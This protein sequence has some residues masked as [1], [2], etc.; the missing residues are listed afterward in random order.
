M[1]W[2]VT[3]YPS[4]STTLWAVLE[5]CVH[6]I[7]SSNALAWRRKQLGYKKGGG[8]CLARRKCVPCC[9]RCRRWCGWWHSC[10]LWLAKSQGQDRWKLLLW[11]SLWDRPQSHFWFKKLDIFK[12]ILRICIYVQHSCLDGG[13]VGSDAIA[14]RIDHVRKANICRRGSFEVSVYHI[15]NFTKQ[16]KSWN[17]IPR[18]YNFAYPRE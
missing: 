3:A 6:V 17:L 8:K 18:N 11:D 10:R 13:G 15:S 4:W 14:E 1:A 2:G 9:N 12:I 7:K 5:I 16:T